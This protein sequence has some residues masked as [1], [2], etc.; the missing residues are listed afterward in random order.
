M[1]KTENICPL[2]WFHT[3]I[4]PN[5]DVYPCCTWDWTKPLGNINNNSIVEIFNNSEYV[6]IRKAMINGESVEGCERCVVLGK[7]GISTQK[8]QAEK[9]LKDECAIYD[10]NERVEEKQIDF[11]YLDYRFSNKCNL[12]CV[13][14]GSELSSSIAIEEKKQFPI[15]NFLKTSK[16]NLRSDILSLSKS[17][18]MIYF[19]G[20]EP[21]IIEEHFDTLNYFIHMGVS[22]KIDLF[23]NSNL[24]NLNWS[25]KNVF[26][27]WKNFKSVCIGASIDHFGK[28]LEFIRHPI[29]YETL[30][31]N[32]KKIKMS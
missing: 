20:G 9:L 8:D 16:K 11:K 25:G 27:I 21:L 24:T 10:F 6:S 23:Y 26:D 22:S 3:H 18:K 4:W 28:K 31:N 2:P 5:G 32:I 1:K 19:A 14:C 12:K 29:K 17:P 7:Y 13:T 30:L 15:T